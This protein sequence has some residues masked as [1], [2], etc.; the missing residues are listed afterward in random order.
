MRLLGGPISPYVRIVRMMIV[1]KGLQD[2]V[3]V[4]M[5]ATRVPDS[6]VHAFNATGKI[7]TLI[8]DDQTA[9]GEA[10]LICEYLDT[11]HSASPFLSPDR[12]PARLAYEGLIAGFLDGIAVY[13]REVRRPSEEQSP[14]IIEQEEARAHRCLER[15]EAD[16]T[17]LRAPDDY[18]SCVMLIAVWRLSY[19]VPSFAWT[20]RYPQ[21]HAWY[22]RACQDESFKATG[23]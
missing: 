2:R 15:F 6:P 21:V 10:R 16:P 22:Q 11:Q 13:I 8:V 12:S 7:P 3:S 4:D 19:S 1:Q 20:S 9:I 23:P 14:G 17:M 18:T 5:V